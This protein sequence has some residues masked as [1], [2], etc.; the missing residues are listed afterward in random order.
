MRRLTVATCACLLLLA[1]AAFAQETPVD[2]APPPPAELLEILQ[3]T[4]PGPEA[5]Y[6][7][8]PSLAPAAARVGLLPRLAPVG[9]PRVIVF[10]P[11]FFPTHYNFR[12]LPYGYPPSDPYFFYGA[13][14]NPY[15]Y[16]YYGPGAYW[17]F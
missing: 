10:H 3:P 12:P 17:G 9:D 4:G 13:L 16:Q 5:V 11:Y 8:P 7:L 2:P 1:P 14:A 15:Y 6:D